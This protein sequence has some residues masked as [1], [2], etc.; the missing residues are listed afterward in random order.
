MLDH[1]HPLITLPHTK[2]SREGIC[3]T[4]R[5][6]GG[7]HHPDTEPFVVQHGEKHRLAFCHANTRSPQLNQM[8]VG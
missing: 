5:F 3:V 1:E 2:V 8:A 4:L 7:V 6:V